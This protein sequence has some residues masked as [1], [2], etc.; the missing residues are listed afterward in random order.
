M[1]PILLRLEKLI[2]SNLFVNKIWQHIQKKKKTTKKIEV[3]QS[4]ATTLF[5]SA[6]NLLSSHEC[7]V[8]NCFLTRTRPNLTCKNRQVIVLDRLII[9]TLIASLNLPQIMTTGGHKI[10]ERTQ[11]GNFFETRY[12][13]TWSFSFI[14]IATI[15]KT[16]ALQR[17]VRFFLAHPVDITQRMMTCMYL[18]YLR[19]TIY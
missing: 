4:A 16:T 2:Y 3:Q 8:L 18:F 7:V 5:T 19:L 11:S 15:T 14:F 17:V 10:C 13:L 12:A 1:L 9:F 6:R